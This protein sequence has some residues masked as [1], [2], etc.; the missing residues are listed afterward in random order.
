MRF[1][2]ELSLLLIIFYCTWSGYRRGAI[3]AAISLAAVLVSVFAALLIAS[4]AAPSMAYPLRPLVAGYIDSQLEEEAARHAGIDETRIEDSI[5]E[6]PELLTPYTESCLES[7]GFD[8]QRAADWSGNAQ[9]IYAEYDIDAT[10]A[11]AHAGSEALAYAICSLIFFPLIMLFISLIKQ[12][13]ALRFRIRDNEELDLYGGAAFGFLRGFA[14]CICLCW[15]LSFCGNIIGK[16][17]LD[18]GLFSRLF[19]V[20]SNV[21]D[22]IF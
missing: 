8:A 14:Y 13:F 10:T 11:A 16:T 22:K 19:L 15:L 4:S 3:N 17:T 12:I 21:A 9:R 5:R 7:L 6:A 18:D 20:L 1:V 2:I